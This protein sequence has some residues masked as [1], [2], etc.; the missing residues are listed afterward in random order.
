MRKNRARANRE[1]TRMNANKWIPD[2][3]IRLLALMKR[4]L[5]FLIGLSATLL[6][7]PYAWAGVHAG[8]PAGEAHVNAIHTAQQGNY[9][10]E[11][12]AIQHSW[13]HIKY[14]APKAERRHAF[15]A[16]LEKSKALSS[17][18]PEQAGAMAWSA[19]ILYNYAG[20]VGGIKALGMVKHAH[21]ILLRAEAINP[22]AA[23]GLIYTALGLLY[24]RV[25]GWPIAF[26]DDARA[27]RYLRKALALHPDGLD[28]NY[29]MGDYLLRKKR[30][31]QAVKYLRRAMQAPP[32]SLF[33]VADAG[34]KADAKDLLQQAE[35][36][37]S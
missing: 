24:Y 15:A 27:E 7:M 14:H 25:P 28:A 22:T 33:S 23:N 30:Y 11:L 12:L 3:G 36:H 6:V 16:L 26:G 5:L 2:R 18:Y 13:A 34:R 19:V 29:F 8:Q 9:H 20:E 37:D 35:K 1:Y 17:Q 4:F 32:R 10:T 31:R 21:R